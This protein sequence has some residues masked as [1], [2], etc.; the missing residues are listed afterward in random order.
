MPD[1]Q[2]SRFRFGQSPVPDYS[3]RGTRFRL[4][5][6]LAAVMFVLGIAERAR[7]PKSWRWLWDL[8]K[9]AQ[10]PERVNPR[11]PPQPLRTEH[12]PPG[13]FVLADGQEKLEPSEQQ[14]DPLARSWQQGW[15]DVYERLQPA[16]R[17]LLF[18]LLHAVAHRRQ[19][20]AEKSTAA[21]ELLARTT[22]LW[23]DYQSV[24]FQAVDKLKGDDQTLWVDVLRRVN[25][26]F[27]D[28]LRPALQAVIDGRSPTEAEERALTGLTETLIALTTA[29]IEDDTVFRPAEREI[30]FHWLAD[31]QA[32]APAELQKRSLGR[33]AYLQLFKQ[34]DDYRGKVVTVKGLARLAYRRQAPANHL[35]IKEYYVYWIHPE[36][37]PTSPIVVYALSA[38]PGFPAIKDK[39][40]S[41][42]E[43]TK[44]REEVEVTG[45]FFKR[46]AYPGQDGTYTA[47]LV[48]AG[49]PTWLPNTIDLTAGRAG[50]TPIELAVA[51]IATLLLVVCVA[52]VVWHRTRRRRPSDEFA[53]PNIASL[54]NVTL[55]P[56]PQ[57]ALQR[58]ERD[59]KSRGE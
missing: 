1:R 24:A 38:P 54:S 51:A 20:A 33:I 50:L 2:P 12:D 46:W 28:G 23:E 21:G 39:D 13:T 48:V 42:G 11:L 19:L 55:A 10:R 53:P 36:G 8:D 34:P 30:W 35:G 22:A 15:K 32:A 5:A 43:G 17:D 45:I 16:E 18:E 7:D 49:V 9:L 59:A 57:E 6:M 4:F 56:S 40:A 31:V 47:P 25:G 3:R 52:A 14:I 41:G 58:M 26:K 37:G 29:Q 44:L 27:S